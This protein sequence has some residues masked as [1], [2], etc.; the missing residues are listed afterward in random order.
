MHG[1]THVRDTGWPGAGTQLVLNKGYVSRRMRRNSGRSKR[2]FLQSKH[3][4]E[5]AYLK[6]IGRKRIK[7]KCFCFRSQRLSSAAYKTAEIMYPQPNIISRLIYGNRTPKGCGGEQAG[8]RAGGE[9]RCDT[10]SGTGHSAA[11]PGETRV[12]P[13]TPAGGGGVWLRH[14]HALLRRMNPVAPR[15]AQPS[16]LLAD[17]G[18]E[19]SIQFSRCGAR[20]PLTSC[21]RQ[22]R[23][24]QLRPRPGPAPRAP[25]PPRVHFRGRQRPWR[26]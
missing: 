22:R 12:R 2:K 23:L 18:C 3:F 7:K 9:G 16:A 19:R 11:G 6:L 24:F 20:R 10:D 8:G 17:A 21:L 26:C 13:P 5:R 15:G 25:R 1:R 4:L 14:R